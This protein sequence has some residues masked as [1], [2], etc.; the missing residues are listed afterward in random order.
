M[1]STQA[2]LLCLPAQTYTPKS[3][4]ACFHQSSVNRASVSDGL[5][6]SLVLGPVSDSHAEGRK[7]Q[8]FRH[9]SANWAAV[10]DWLTSFPSVLMECSPLVNS[11]SVRAHR[12]SPENSEKAM[13]WSLPFLNVFSSVLGHYPVSDSW[14]LTETMLFE[15]LWHMLLFCDRMPWSSW[16]FIV[17][18]PN[19]QEFFFQV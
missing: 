6:N 9:S 10:N 15:T 2:K 12:R 16:D 4:G 3:G 14:R 5:W 7:P 13:F 11:I 19:C 17:P 8:V 1:Q 18:V